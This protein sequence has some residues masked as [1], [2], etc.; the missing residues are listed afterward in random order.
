MFEKSKAKEGPLEGQLVLNIVIEWDFMLIVHPA[1]RVSIFL[2]SYHW[3]C[4]SEV[5]SWY[6]VTTIG[7]HNLI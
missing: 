5:K 4:G 1:K 2:S 3:Q 7:R 6:E